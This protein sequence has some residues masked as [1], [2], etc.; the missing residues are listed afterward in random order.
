MT[1][2][3][4][5]GSGLVVAAGIAACAP[6]PP[7][8]E[9]TDPFAGAASLPSA[10]PVETRPLGGPVAPPRTVVTGPA[11]GTGPDA[12]AGPAGGAAGD[13]PGPGGADAPAP[14]TASD[15]VTQVNPGGLVERLPNT[16]QLENYQQFVGQDGASA[17]VQVVDRPARVIAPDDI[18]SQVYDPRRV[19]LYVDGSGRV[20][21]ISCG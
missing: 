8:E 17:A 10:E 4:Q 5:V 6:P 20:T 13:I 15:T 18:V 21:R 1:R 16:C 7:Y 2:L 11:A 14:A 9:V 3:F 19:N 12:P